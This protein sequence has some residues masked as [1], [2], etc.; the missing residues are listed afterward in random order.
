MSKTEPFTATL[1]DGT[2]VTIRPVVPED[3]PRLQ[4]LYNHLSPE[5]I[6]YRFLSQAKELTRAQAERL[7]NVD[8]DARMAFVATCEMDSDTPIIGVARYAEGLEPC[9]AEAGVVVQDRYQRLGLGTILLSELTEYARSQGIH[10]FVAWIHQSN[11]AILQFI[12][13]SGLPTQSRLESGTWE[14]R[15]TL[16]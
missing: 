4:A 1:R 7:A 14:I 11:T 8:Y 3:A 6:Y 16:D 15:V 9:V 13:R 2:N 10:T 12:R 5:S